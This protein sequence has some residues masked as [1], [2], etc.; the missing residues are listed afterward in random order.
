MILAYVSVYCFGLIVIPGRFNASQYYSENGT[1]LIGTSVESINNKDQL[2]YVI[3]VL[4]SDSYKIEILL[5]Q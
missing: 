2:R 4:G 1:T 3:D 5:S